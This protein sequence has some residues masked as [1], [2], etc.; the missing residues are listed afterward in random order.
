MTDI[1]Y[2][3]L[4]EMFLFKFYFTKCREQLSAQAK[5]QEMLITGYEWSFK[6]CTTANSGPQ[7]SM[8]EKRCIS[9]GVATYID[10]RSHIGQNLLQQAHA[11]QQ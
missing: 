6:Q 9:Q 2:G 4:I 7:L 10:A 1:F 3:K 5:M 8:K 11:S